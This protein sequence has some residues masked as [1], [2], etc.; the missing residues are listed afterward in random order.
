MTERGRDQIKKDLTELKTHLLQSKDELVLQ[1]N[2]A[3]MEAKDELSKLEKPWNEFMAKVKGLIEDAEEF[4]EE[5]VESAEK[6][7][8]NLKEKY[9]EIKEK[10]TD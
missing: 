3:K 7:G 8:E 4:T 1:M 9:R 5:A 2:L 6:M 10:I